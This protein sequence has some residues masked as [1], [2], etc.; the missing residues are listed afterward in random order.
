MTPM[1]T[2]V[3]IA[4]AAIFIALFLWL[5]P[6]DANRRRVRRFN[7]YALVYLAAI[8]VLDFIACTIRAHSIQLALL[9][10]DLYVLLFVPMYVAGAG[11]LRS[12]LLSKFH[13][14]GR[15]TT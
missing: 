9:G 12:R 1:E 5:S 13:G 7:G 4:V 8:C 11:L 10:F 14:G 6:A 2:Y 15:S 3:S